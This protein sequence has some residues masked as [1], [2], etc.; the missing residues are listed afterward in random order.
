MWLLPSLRR[1]ASRDNA[2]GL[3][4]QS[5]R[6]DFTIIVVSILCKSD[7]TMEGGMV[8]YSR[9]HYAKLYANTRLLLRC[10]PRTAR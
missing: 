10:L 7:E 9:R 1:E 4:P 3:Q 8:T 5:H 2:Q 6:V